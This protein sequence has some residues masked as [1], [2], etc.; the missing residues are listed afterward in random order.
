MS[1]LTDL[2][3]EEREVIFED[4]DEITRDA[5]L[6][7]SK[8]LTDG[9]KIALV[10]PY[11]IGTIVN[12]VYEAE[13]LNESQRKQEI[14]KLAAYWNQPQIGPTTL[15]DWRNIAAAFD[16]DF[17]I[18]QAEEKMSNGQ[19]LTLSHFKE[20]QKVSNEKRQLT[21]LKKVRQHCWSANELALE[22]QGKKEAEV[23]RSGGRKP[24]LPRTPNGML[25]KLFTSV[26]AADN[27]VEAVS[28]PL[29]G[30]FLEMPATEVDDRF[31][32]SIDNTMERMDKLTEHVK[33]AYNRLKKIRARADKVR[34]GTDAAAAAAETEQQTAMAAKSS[35]EEE[36]ASALPKASKKKRK[37]V[38]SGK[39]AAADKDST[40][41]KVKRRGKPRRAGTSTGAEEA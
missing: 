12:R 4:M 15:Y 19:Y 29:G 17:V 24:T 35:P 22:L 23:K 39:H 16:R 6:A 31:V 3:A 2:S 27:Y 26:Q 5:A 18:A 28:E 25:Q 9:Y 11:D 36:A 13:H 32:E 37:N 38:V 21:L 8:R 14:K 7:G 34:S 40:R 1:A 41:K 30:V 33:E 10:I 20:L